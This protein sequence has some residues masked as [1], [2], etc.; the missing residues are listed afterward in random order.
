MW[1]SHTLTVYAQ[2]SE[3]AAA[4]AHHQAKGTRVIASLDGQVRYVHN[5]KRANA[6]FLPASTFKVANTLIALDLDLVQRATD[7][8]A[9]DGEKYGITIKP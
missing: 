9:W 8:F 2:D 1:L 7:A 5:P 4:F 3:L 6:Q